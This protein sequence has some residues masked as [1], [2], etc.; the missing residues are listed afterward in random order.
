[1]TTDPAPTTLL[2]P[3][4]TPS[5][6]MTPAPSQTSSPIRIPPLESE[7]WNMMGVDTSRKL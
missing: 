6:T 3:I 4:V 7:G 2:F 5:K 1:V